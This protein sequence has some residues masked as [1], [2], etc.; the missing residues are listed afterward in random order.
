MIVKEILMKD[1]ERSKSILYQRGTF[2]S[3]LRR[4]WLDVIDH[5]EMFENSDESNGDTDNGYYDTYEEEELQAMH[6]EWM[7][8]MGSEYSD[9]DD[10]HFF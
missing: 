5:P 8:E 2:D 4:C 3:N 1:V 9:G 7:A 10:Y 6:E